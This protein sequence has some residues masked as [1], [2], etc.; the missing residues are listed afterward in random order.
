[1]FPTLLGNDSVLIDTTQKMLNL[2]DRVWAISLYGAAAIKRLRT[3]G[4][5]R[6]LVISDNPAVENQE[7]DADDIIIGGRIIWFARD[8]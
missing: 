6:V 8:L 3:I 7:V 1:M 2:N 4:P 5:N